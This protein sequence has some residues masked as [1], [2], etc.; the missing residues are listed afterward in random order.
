MSNAK[1]PKTHEEWFVGV[2]QKFDVE[3]L[4]REKRW[5]NA[6][7]WH[8]EYGEN[9]RRYVKTKEQAIEV[10]NNAYKLWNG[11]KIYNAKG[12]RYETQSCGM[13]GISTVHT[14]ETDEDMR[15]VEHI[16][17]KR[18]VTEWETIDKGVM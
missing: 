7:G 5:F 17:Q 9:F 6:I 12:E 1:A 14:K 4:T 18:V 15:I 10:L 13:I 11:E 3:R 16:I 8:R 2:R